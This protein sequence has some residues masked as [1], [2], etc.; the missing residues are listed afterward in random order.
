MGRL[1]LWVI[2]AFALGGAR[3][4][5]LEA[6][7][8]GDYLRNMAGGIRE[9]TAYLTNIDFTLDM[10]VQAILGSS[11]ARVF[12]YALHNN[13]T[14]FSTPIVGDA[15]FVS[16]IDAPGAL[17]LY[18]LWY[19][20][21]LGKLSARFGLYDLN[22]EF[23]VIEA[24]G[25]FIQSS[26]GIGAEFAQSGINGP[27]IF[28]VTSL[29]LRLQTA[30]G[31]AATLRYVILDGVP[32]DPN[33]FDRTTVKLGNGDGVLQTLELDSQIHARLRLT[34]GYWRYSA[35]FDYLD[36]VDALGNNLRGDGN[37][38]WYVSAESQITAAVAGGDVVAFIRYGR[39]NESF[40][41]FGSYLGAGFVVNA[42]FGRRNARLGL[43]MAR[44]GSG[45]SLRRLVPGTPRSETSLELTYSIQITPWLRLQPDLQY[46]INPGVN[47]ALKD[48]WVVGLRMEIGG[49]WALDSR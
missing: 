31:E 37:D 27:S 38:G 14:T 2:S 30:L 33:D 17:R 40:N 35:D 11:S 49:S 39:A 19:E 42:P 12:A 1:L 4:A 29:G 45:D 25:L 15:Q 13:D 47:P 10:P 9:D 18:E 43:A 6:S 21:D 34:A 28:P 23:D 20:Q 48:A 8:S 32:G 16:N 41:S 24:A 5:T 7:F 3:A 22:S 26:H 36:R 44:A 46:V